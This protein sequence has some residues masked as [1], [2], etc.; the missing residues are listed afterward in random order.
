MTKGK[1][2]DNTLIIPFPYMEYL[3]W[4]RY[5][6]VATLTDF[7]SFHST[8]F[9]LQHIGRAVCA[10]VA[11]KSVNRVQLHTQQIRFTFLMTGQVIG[12][13]AVLYLLIYLD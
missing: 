6:D 2:R 9:N 5:V 1:Q 13:L 4:L 12:M 7:P 3:D 11:T 10:C 8:I